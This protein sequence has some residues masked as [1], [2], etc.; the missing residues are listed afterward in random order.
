MPYAYKSCWFR[1]L[2]LF[3][4]LCLFGSCVIC[5]CCFFFISFFTK[6]I[7]IYIIW[8]IERCSINGISHVEN[9]PSKCFTQ[10]KRNKSKTT[11]NELFEIFTNPKIKHYSQ[12]FWFWFKIKRLYNFIIWIFHFVSYSDLMLFFSL[13][14][15]ILEPFTGK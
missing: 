11:L 12:L 5:C 15:V 9:F 7:A 4:F 6:W 3:S 2:L 13:S 14:L 1:C 10:K 8:S